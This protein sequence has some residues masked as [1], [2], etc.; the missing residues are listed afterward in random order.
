MTQ[1]YLSNPPV[2][3]AGDVALVG[4]LNRDYLDL[5]SGTG[6]HE[7]LGVELLGALRQADAGMRDAIAGCSYSLF[8]LRFPE[9][10]AGEWSALPQVQDPAAHRYSAL[11]GDAGTWPAFITTAWFFAWHLSRNSPL[12]ARFMLWLHPGHAALLADFAPWQ[13]RHLAALQP[14]PLPPRWQSNPCFWPD[15]IRFARNHQSLRLTAAQLLG[16]QLLAADIE[17]S[18][19]RTRR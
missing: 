6:P 13:L 4:R 17:L 10:A 1:S 19:P 3:A 14:S 15:L 18:P 2:L 7:L 8:T 12:S 11:T 9:G 5:L 16:V